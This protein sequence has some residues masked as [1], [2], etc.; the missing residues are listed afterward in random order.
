MR[1]KKDGT[2]CDWRKPHDINVFW[3]RVNKTRTCWLW[4]GATNEKGYGTFRGGKNKVLVHRFAWKIYKGRWPKRGLKVLHT[5]DVTNCMREEHLFEGTDADN[6]RDM[7]SK[8][9]EASG[10]RSGNSVLTWKEVRDIRKSTASQS[11]LSEVYGVNQS[12]ISHI[13]NNH[14]WKE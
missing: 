9:R 12:T 13:V 2:P 7:L 1:V 5:C 6:T 4:T 11:V 8:G 3:S 14:T 10:E